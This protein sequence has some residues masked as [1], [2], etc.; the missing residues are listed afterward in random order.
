MKPRITSNSVPGHFGPV[1]LGP[2]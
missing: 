1:D 2:F